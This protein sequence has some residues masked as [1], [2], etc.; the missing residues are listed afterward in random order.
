MFYVFKKSELKMF[1]I[2]TD[3]LFTAIL[4]PETQSITERPFMPKWSHCLLLRDSEMKNLM[5][6]AESLNLNLKASICIMFIHHP[7]QALKRNCNANTD[8]MMSLHNT[9]RNP[10]SRSLS[11]VTLTEWLVKLIPK[12]RS[13]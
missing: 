8:S 5:L 10:K 1:Q 6:K 13:S 2:L 9:S 4:H 7:V 3:T 11:V 12:G